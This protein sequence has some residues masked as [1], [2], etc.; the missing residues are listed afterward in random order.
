MKNNLLTILFEENKEMSIVESGICK[1]GSVYILTQ[2]A[3]NEF[4]KYKFIL[5]KLSNTLREINIFDNE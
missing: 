1:V 4:K 5:K 3:F 2:E